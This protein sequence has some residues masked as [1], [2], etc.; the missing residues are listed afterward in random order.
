MALAAGGGVYALT[1]GGGPANEVVV[2]DSACAFG[3][4]APSS[5]RTV[6]TIRN[7]SPT[8]VYTVQ[9]VGSS[10]G[11]VYG[12]QYMV[13]PGT[14]APLDAVLP[15][16]GYSFQCQGANGYL[17]VSPSEQ[18]TGPPVTGAH[19]YVQVTGQQIQLAVDGYRASLMPLMR[20]LQ[21]DTDSLTAAMRAGELAR[22]RTL[23]LPAHL[24]YSRLGVAY[25]TFGKYN[26]LIDGRPSGLQGG[27]ENPQFRGFLRLEYG[28]WHG[29]SQAELVPVADDLQQSVHGLV[30]QFPTMPFVNGDLAL[31]AHE[32]LENTLQFE[33]TGQTNEGSN[34][35]LATAWANVQGTSL[36]LAALQPLLH[37]V[38]PSL[39]TTVTGGV[40][41]LGSLLHAYEQPDGRWV[42]LDA[43]TTTEREQIDS[44]TSGLLE[45]LSLVPDLLTPSGAAGDSGD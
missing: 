43:L 42:A 9:I 38:D 13:A 34:T 40:S 29:Q 20:R 33:L 39:L 25:D 11:A 6:F 8:T 7:E 17:L 19:P 31:R 10:T 32:I 44:A 16:G 30:R 2:S 24:D 14:E 1:R 23:W 36:A 18:V 22:A 27:V 5:G 41:R 37:Q 4:K 21:T 28:L 26:A 3:W 35:N 12:Q 15:P 45:H